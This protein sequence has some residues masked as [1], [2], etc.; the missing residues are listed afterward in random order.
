MSAFI[1][2]VDTWRADVPWPIFIFEIIL[3]PI[4]LAALFAPMP[5]AIA[6]IK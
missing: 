3:T 4:V 2:W 6:L 1:A 5:L